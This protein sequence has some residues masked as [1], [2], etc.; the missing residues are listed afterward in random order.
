VVDFI[1]TTP[2]ALNLQASPSTIPTQGQS[3][4]TATVRDANNNLVQGQT[5]DFSITQDPTGGTLSAASAVTND[6]GQASTVYSASGTTS[7]TN[8]VSI[9]ASIPGTA[10]TGMTS[11]T[12]AGETVFLSL[13]TG[14]T[15]SSLNAT[16]YSMPYTVQAVDSAGNPVSG[17]TV[18]FTVNSVG[19][20]K[21]CRL[22]N[23]VGTCG[24]NNPAASGT[25]AWEVAS[26][27]AGEEQAD[28]AATY[29]SSDFGYILDGGDGCASM[30]PDN[31]GILEDDY[32]PPNKVIWPGQVVSTDVGSGVTA[33]NGTATVNLIY[34]K[35]HAGYVAAE[36]T[37]TATVQGTASSTFQTFWLPVLA[38][39]VS[40]PTLE[41]PGPFS[42]YGMGALCSDAN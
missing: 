30:D 3:A 34:P 9:S 37:A 4:L 24:G 36:L 7:G 25:G 29:V 26:D 8:G 28:G 6:Q 11:L 23:L 33:T 17:I 42:P 10:V 32:N 1:A 41:P 22:W 14:N 19:Y 27:T 38:A 31:N 13:G 20:I 16:Q 39:D 40:S 35:D 2:T 12:V 5:V 18:T 15:I 21:G